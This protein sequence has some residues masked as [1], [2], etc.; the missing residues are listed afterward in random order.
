MSYTNGIANLQ[1]ALA[2]L[3]STST[4]PV[5]DMV[6]GMDR[7]ASVVVPVQEDQASLSFTGGAMSQALGASDV[8]STKVAALQQAI[9][10]GSYKV[11][12]SDVAEKMI[13][14]LLE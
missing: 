5:T 11:P 7:G 12:S 2:S 10:S 13:D 3:A 8:R 1:Q 9:A 4:K 14:S 6:S